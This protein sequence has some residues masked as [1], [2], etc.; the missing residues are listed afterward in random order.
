LSNG[1]VPV[2]FGVCETGQGGFA[3]TTMAYVR[4]MRLRCVNNLKKGCGVRTVPQTFPDNTDFH[5]LL[6][7]KNTLSDTCTP[8]PPETTASSSQTSAQQSLS[9]PVYKNETHA[10][11]VEESAPIAALPP[12]ATTRI[13]ML[14]AE[15]LIKFLS[16]VIPG[17]IHDKWQP[18]FFCQLFYLRNELTYDQD[19]LACVVLLPFL[20][21]LISKTSIA[22][23]E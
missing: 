16:F 17:L 10:L 19:A 20:A 6:N 2:L 8:A 23:S 18:Q 21:S 13:L 4:D 11:S 22:S 14:P 7:L 9:T 15:L 5:P 12:G 3:F 1:F